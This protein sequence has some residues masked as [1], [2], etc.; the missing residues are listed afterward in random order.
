M[1]TETDA[2][3]G[4][5]K[6]VVEVGWG[7]VGDRSVGVGRGEGTVTWPAPRSG[8]AGEPDGSMGAE[9]GWQPARTIRAA[10]ATSAAHRRYFI[11]H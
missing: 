8:I 4:D 6:G 9:A 2:V 1:A 10:G 3:G 5:L 11:F 7:L